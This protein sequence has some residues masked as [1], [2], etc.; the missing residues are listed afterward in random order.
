M[1]EQQK[2]FRSKCLDEFDRDLSVLLGLFAGD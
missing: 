1:I 2:I